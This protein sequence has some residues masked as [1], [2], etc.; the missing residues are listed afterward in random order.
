MPVDVPHA[1]MRHPIAIEPGT[2]ATAWGVVVP[3]LP[4]CFSAGDTMEE[5][6]I[7]AGEAVTAWIETALDAG[8][9]IPQPSAIDALLEAS[10]IQADTPQK[11]QSSGRRLF[12]DALNGCDRLQVMATHARL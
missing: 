1:Q 3:D 10:Q 6:L 4:V 5:A 2:E 8:Q 9:A 7:Q 12:R 11:G